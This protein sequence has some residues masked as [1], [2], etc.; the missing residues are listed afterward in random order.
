[1]KG[2]SKN[3]MIAAR[4]EKQLATR[5][6]ALTKARAD[7][8]KEQEKLSKLREEVV[9]SIQGESVYSKEM[10]AGLV[11]ETDARVRSLAANCEEA[12]RELESKQVMM[13]ELSDSY[14]E[15]ISWSELYD[16]ASFEAKKMIVNAM[17]SRVDVYKDY[18]L[19][20]ELNFNIRQFFEGLDEDVAPE[21]VSA[22]PK[23]A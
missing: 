11:D 19:E 2:I 5:K 16:S 8:A 18:R 1:M 6:C 23:T 14:D 10:L 9:R 13:K 12:E 17:I 21:P 7:L 3:E 22:L 20:I 4:Y 15:I